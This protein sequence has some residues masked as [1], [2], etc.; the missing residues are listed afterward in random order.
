MSAY[1][2]VVLTISGSTHG[3]QRIYLTKGASM[4]VCDYQGT[5]GGGRTFTFLSN[6]T[7]IKED[8]NG[9]SYGAYGALYVSEIYGIV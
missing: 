9:N 7:G 3:N 4:T 5:S 1:S 2:A 8:I 6:G